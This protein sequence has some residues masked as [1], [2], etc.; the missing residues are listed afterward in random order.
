[1]HVLISVVTAV[2]GVDKEY[3]I[4]YMDLIKYPCH[5]LNAGLA[6]VC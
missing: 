1:M 5:N 3:L 4:F 2:Y 6:N